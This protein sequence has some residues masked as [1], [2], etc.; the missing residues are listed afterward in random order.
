MT[1]ELY[2][3]VPA[4]QDDFGTA[5][6]NRDDAEAGGVA[7][8]PRVDGLG[9]ARRVQGCAH[10]AGLSMSVYHD[11]VGG[12]HGAKSAFA[13]LTISAGRMGKAASVPIIKLECAPARIRCRARSS[14]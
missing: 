10:G 13:L 14:N 3:V 11:P 5:R 2:Q 1:E 7:K 8:T 9:K 4:R 6:L 12:G